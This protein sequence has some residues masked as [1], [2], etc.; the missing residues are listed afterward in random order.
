ME[1]HIMRLIKKGKQFTSNLL[2][3]FRLD[4]YIHDYLV[5]KGMHNTAETFANEA[6]VINPMNVAI[7]SPE[8][9]LMEW[10]DVFY[11]KFSSNKAEHVQ[12]SYAEAA[13][14]VDNVVPHIPSAVPTSSPH[15]ARPA[16]N[17]SP[18][19]LAYSPEQCQRM[20]PEDDVT[21]N[22]KLHVMDCPSQKVPF[23]TD[24]SPPMEQIPNM[25]QLRESRDEGE[26]ERTMQMEPNLDAFINAMLSVPE[27]S[28]AGWK[29]LYNDLTDNPQNYYN[30][31]NNK[32][33]LR[34]ASISHQKGRTIS[35]IKT[36][37]KKLERV[38]SKF[39]ENRKR[40]VQHQ[41][42]KWPSSSFVSSEGSVTAMAYRL[43]HVDSP[44]PLANSLLQPQFP[45]ITDV[46]NY[47]VPGTP[48]SGDL[49]NHIIESPRIGDSV[50]P[51]MLLKLLEP[52]RREDRS[53]SEHIFFVL[54]AGIKKLVPS[55]KMLNAGL[56]QINSTQA[57]W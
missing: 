42:P 46:T 53:L 31:K 28:E 24:Y 56:M 32:L 11:E 34:Q 37:F 3:N 43:P 54:L 49:H 48:T 40:R 7:K 20:T 29:H 5:K 36:G 51:E 50:V 45:G 13:R 15:S 35:D 25:P 38:V 27:L 55:Y 17:I 12:E 19:V 30:Q 47:Q 22:L 16:H 21:S 9:L 14:T 6:N 2:A 33:I 26:G 39:K 1:R 23:V 4:K 44:D 52:Y 8:G 10:W 18:V 41:R 57:A